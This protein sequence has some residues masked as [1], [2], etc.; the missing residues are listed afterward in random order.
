LFSVLLVLS[1]IALLLTPTVNSQSYTTITSW[2]TETSQVTST[3]YSTFAVGTTT[4]TSTATNIVMNEYS[5]TLPALSARACYYADVSGSFHAG[6][7]LDGKVVA[8]S[9]MDFY[10]MSSAQFQPF[11]HG[12]CDQ[13]YPALVTARNVI[14]SYSLNW[15]VPVD[16]TYYFVF[17]NHASWGSGTNQVV[18]SFSLE[19]SESQ[20]ST[21]T[22]TGWS[23][24]SNLIT[25]AMT[26]TASSVYSS[27]V[28]TFPWSN[29]PTNYIEY[30]VVIVVLAAI[31]LGAIFISGKRARKP[32]AAKAKAEKG[33]QFCINCGA[34]L[35][36]RSKFCNKC[37]SA[38]S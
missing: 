16:G 17:F 5:F 19:N 9:V 34:E 4:Q 28:Q 29:L 6:D 20:S 3:S 2:T 13:Q 10:V 15:T 25:F 18:G 37:G 23:T 33:V 12:R 31:A 7:K 32:T 24:A 8:S 26:M 36:P 38:Q 14:S 22:L 21:L 27:T 11:S 1:A 35:P 30:L